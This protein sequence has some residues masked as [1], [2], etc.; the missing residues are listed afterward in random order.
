MSPVLD[1]LGVDS[2][3]VL[4]HSVA[5]TDLVAAVEVY[6]FKVE[7][8]DVAWEV[9]EAGEADVDEEVGAASGNEKDTDRGDE[10]GDDNDKD[11]VEWVRHFV[12]G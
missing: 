8:V 6:V 1:I 11:G 5:E 2:R 7:R 3:G 9:A 12:I 10:D 4:Q